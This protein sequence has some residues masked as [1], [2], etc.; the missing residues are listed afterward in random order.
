ML[1]DVFAISVKGCLPCRNGAIQVPSSYTLVKK[2]GSGACALFRAGY[3]LRRAVQLADC[4]LRDRTTTSGLQRCVYFGTLGKRSQLSFSHF[5]GA[6]AT[7]NSTH[8]RQFIVFESRSRL[9]RRSTNH[10]RPCGRH[11][12]QPPSLPPR[13]SPPPPPK[14]TAN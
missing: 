10:V 4:G 9:S 5:F 1:A 14:W 13:P 3:S 2:L 11:Q 12:H 7:S 8:S 6:E